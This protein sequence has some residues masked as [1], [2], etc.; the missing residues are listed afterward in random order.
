MKYWHGSDGGGWIWDP[1]SIGLL[2]ILTAILTAMRCDAMRGARR[3][4]RFIVIREGGKEQF[5]SAA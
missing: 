5:T 4:W 2:A 1:A 3:R